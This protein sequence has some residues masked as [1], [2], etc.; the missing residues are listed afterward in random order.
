MSVLN[1]V[2]T[3]S[4][5]CILII[6][7]VLDWIILLDIIQKWVG[8]VNQYAIYV[9]QPFAYTLLILLLNTMVYKYARKTHNV[10]VLN[11]RN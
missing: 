4:Q 11:F 9:L 8:R 2:I 7:L 5:M 6:F 1:L 3:S 10:A